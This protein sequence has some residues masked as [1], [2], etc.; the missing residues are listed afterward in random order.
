MKNIRGFRDFFKYSALFGSVLFLTVSCGGGG[1]DG[2]AVSNLTYTGLT[3]AAVITDDN[4]EE[5][6]ENALLAA[7]ASSLNPLGVA[8][9]TTSSSRPSARLLDLVTTVSRLGSK[10]DLPTGAATTVTVTGAMNTINNEIVN[11]DCG[12]SMNM[13]G[14]MDDVSGEFSLNVNF[15]NMN[16]CDG[17]I[18]G[19]ASMSGNL[20][21]T[22]GAASFKMTFSRLSFSDATDSMTMNGYIRI[23]MN[24]SGAATTTM[25]M[26]F[27]DNKANKVYR[28]NYT[29][30]TSYDGMNVVMTMTGRFYHPDY[31]YIDINTPVALTMGP[32]DDYPSSGQVVVTGGAGSVG[33]T[34]VRAT[35]QSGD[36][37]LLE[38][39]LD[40]D[41]V[42]ES[43]ET[44]TLTGGCIALVA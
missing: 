1:G 6:V 20:D 35:F 40:G 37:Y 30:N 41:G 29:V 28:V 13:S 22:T 7:D 39:D 21:S 19:Q 34:R 2:G 33:P 23:E 5:L 9:V 16:N 18:N 32:T 24:S 42:Y 17:V 27:R 44:C 3:T 26:D 4:K 14:T 38:S 25:Q 11:G 15:N 10:L 12:G 43:S 31:G 8:T 36:S